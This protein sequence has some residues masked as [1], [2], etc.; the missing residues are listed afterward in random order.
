MEWS[1]VEWSG[2]EWSGVEWGGV[3]WSGVECNG[4][5]LSGGQPIDHQTLHCVSTAWHCLHICCWN[6]H[7]RLMKTMTSQHERSQAFRF[8]VMTIFLPDAFLGNQWAGDVGVD[9]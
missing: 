5:E 1:G 6:P 8:H 2:V 3:E 7:G 4:V 9:S